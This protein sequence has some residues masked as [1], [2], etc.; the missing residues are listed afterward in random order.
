MERILSKLKIS[1]QILA[2]GLIGF[3]GIVAIGG[4]Y[5]WN[6]ARQEAAEGAMSRAMARRATATDIQIGMLEA[7]R[8]EKDFLL[9]RNADYAER[10][11]ATLKDL[12]RAL[13]LLAGDTTGTDPS[14]LTTAVEKGVRRYSAQFDEVRRAAET[15]GLD[16]TKG[17]LGDL[18]TAV[19]DIEE[20]LRAVHAP[21]VQISM[22]MMRR[23]EKDFLARLDPKYGHELKQQLSQFDAALESAPVEPTLKAD[24]HRQMAVYQQDFF[25]MMEAK[26]A[27][28]ARVKDLSAIYLELEPRLTELGQRIAQEY[29]AVRAARDHIRQ[30]GQLIVLIG[31]GLTAVVVA[32]GAWIVGRGVSR[33]IVELTGVTE[34]LAEG[35]I[36]VQ[37]GATGR[38][39]EVGRLARSLAVFKDNI[40]ERDRLAEAQRHEQT[41]KEARQRRVE[42]CVVT[43]DGLVEETLAT[44]GRA[45]DDMHGTAGAMSAN[46]E[47]TNRQAGAVAAAAEQAS[48][49]VQTVAA[50]AEEM[51]TSIAEITRQVDRSNQVTAVA[52]EEAAKTTTTVSDLSVA[53]EKIGAVVELINQIAAQT[54]LL[55]LNAT[56]EASR[57]GEAGKGFAVVAS[58]VKNLANQTAKATE[59]IATQVATM[60]SA[61][62]GAVA[63]IGGINRTITNVSEIST[64]IASAI[65][66]QA[67]A[68][69]EITRNAHEAAKGTHEVSRNISGVNQAATETGTAA[70]QVLSAADE[71]RRRAE[72]MRQQV[73]D[74]LRQIQLA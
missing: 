74:F 57:A 5:V 65:E 10:H 63:A 38:N 23:H 1:H 11:A 3:V 27:E 58:E 16:E 6:L 20:K 44:L 45:A 51:S 12:E 52:V 34:Q 48:A 56:I 28:V 43:F 19:H 4:M 26:L 9:R 47:E 42:E 40:I 41:K 14:E 35:N 62:Q 8:Q 29:D 59:E 22:L 68:T 72:T 67:A 17:L 50:A 37:V 13:S 71:L 7:R 18:R 73:D 61:T 30:A 33:P 55:A 31:I 60:Q 70:S 66:E 2:I 46:A 64:A 21:D 36:M 24:M 39:D 69:K 54:N 49:N 32:L 53:A 25:R 15:V